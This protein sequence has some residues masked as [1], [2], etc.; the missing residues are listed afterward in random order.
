MRKVLIE[1]PGGHERLELVDAPDPEP[2]P[3]EV[4]VETEAIGVNFPDIAVRMGL[5]ESAKKLVGWPITPGFEFAGRARKAG[6][7]S[8]VAVG[9]R[10]F[11]VT[12]FGGYASLVAV[13][14]SHVFVLVPKLS[15]VQGAT[16]S[17]VFLTAWYGLRE[18]VRLR[19]GMTL[20]IHSA[21]GGVGGAFVQVGKAMGCRVVGVVGSTKKVA[22]AS[23]LGAEAVIDKSRESLWRAAERHVPDGYDVVCDANGVETL[24]ESYRHLKPTGR[25][26]IYGFHSM[27]R[28][29]RDRPSYPKLIYDYL[30][31]PR[32]NPLR[33]TGDNKCILAYNLS[34]LFQ[35]TDLLRE[36]MNE[37]LGWLEAGKIRP[38]PVTEYPFESVALAHRALESGETTGKLALIPG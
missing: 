12:L 5:Y 9:Q 4:L 26:I 38:L 7:G 35:R 24:R 10:V 23:E 18:L 37:L 30:R 8:T 21:A 22:L 17:V 31:T 6:A 3:G 36:A 15:P 25:L 16:F 28:K 27:L 2:A 11:G 1:K 19:P 20:L 33:L 29:G 14:E 32:F 34:Y 13:P